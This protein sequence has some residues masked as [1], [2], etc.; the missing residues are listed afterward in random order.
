MGE[1]GVDSVLRELAAPR[2]G[3]AGFV[4][5]RSRSAIIVSIAL[6]IGGSVGKLPC[7]CCAADITRRA[8]P[9]AADGFFTRTPISGGSTKRSP[10]L[11]PKG[12]YRFVGTRT[13][14]CG[15]TLMRRPDGRVRSNQTIPTIIRFGSGTQ[16]GTPMLATRS[17]TRIG[18]QAAMYM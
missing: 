17:S 10:R 5:P 7:G 9:L 14:R 15:S 4:R 8:K 6:A 2:T 13:S 3:P 18:R 16:H 12:C 1:A 11:A